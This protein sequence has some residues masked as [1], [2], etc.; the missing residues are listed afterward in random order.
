MLKSF[1]ALAMRISKDIVQNAVNDTEGLG[2]KDI[3]GILG[4]LGLLPFTTCS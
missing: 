1:R 4:V 3:V 2:E